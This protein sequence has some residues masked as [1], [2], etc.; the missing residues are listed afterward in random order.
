MRENGLGCYGNVER[1][2]KY[3]IVKKVRM[4]GLDGSRERGRLRRQTFSREL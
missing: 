1:R 3:D 2:N 4:V